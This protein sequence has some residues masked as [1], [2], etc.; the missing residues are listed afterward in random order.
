M[1]APGL[2]LGGARGIAVT[3]TV[4]RPAL[5]G[6]TVQCGAERTWTSGWMT[7]SFPVVTGASEK[8]AE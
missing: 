1:C 7:R 3:G 4:P 8:Y 2:V 6:L 5:M